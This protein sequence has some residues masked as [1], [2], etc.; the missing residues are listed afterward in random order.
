MVVTVIH[1]SRTTFHI[2]RNM[3]ESVSKKCGSWIVSDCFMHLSWYNISNLHFVVFEYTIYIP[4]TEKLY[5]SLKEQKFAALKDVKGEY[6]TPWAKTT[7]FTVHRLLWLCRCRTPASV[8][9]WTE[10]LE[11]NMANLSSRWTY[12]FITDSVQ[13]SSVT[14]NK[15]YITVDGICNFNG[16]RVKGIKEILWFNS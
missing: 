5:K 10:S 13:I 3:Q 15:C 2:S 8:K 1:S 14:S 12:T 4:E 16:T 6:Q 9:D 7:G 11:S